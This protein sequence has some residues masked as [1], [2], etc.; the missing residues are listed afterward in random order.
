MCARIVRPSHGGAG[1]GR[2]TWSARI[3]LGALRW[4]LRWPWTCV[5]GAVLVAA[6][7]VPLYGVVKQDYIPSDVDEGEFEVN[8]NGPEGAGADMEAA[9]GLEMV[10]H[11]VCQKADFAVAGAQ[12]AANASRWSWRRA[13]SREQVPG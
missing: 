8:V 9:P 10:A 6:S 5:A 13:G 3:Y 1:P 11:Q 12:R 7:V 4:C 2:P